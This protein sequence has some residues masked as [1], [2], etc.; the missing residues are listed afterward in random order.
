MKESRETVLR[1]Y[2]IIHEEK[3]ETGMGEH[4]L[5]PKFFLAF[6]EKDI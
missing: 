1:Q 4:T 6:L 5:R 2:K 3:K